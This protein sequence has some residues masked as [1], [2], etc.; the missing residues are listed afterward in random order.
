MNRRLTFAMGEFVAEF[1]VDRQYARNHMWVQSR[2]QRYRCGFSAYAVQ[3]LQDVYFL[4]WTVDTGTLLRA[5]DPIGSI[6]SK[7]A[8]RLLYAPVKGTLIR[9]NDLLRDDPS[10]INVAP[11]NAGWLFEC[12]ADSPSLLTPLEYIANLKN[13]WEVTQRKLGGPLT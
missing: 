6:E 9:F 8:E 1:P 12:D 2:E 7:K 13:E 3:L 5:Q 10:Y 4:D 11:Y